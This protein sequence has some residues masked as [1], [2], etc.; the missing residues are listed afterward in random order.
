MAIYDVKG[1]EVSG[2]AGGMDVTGLSFYNDGT[3]TERQG[4]LTYAGHKLYPVNQRT[5][6]KLRPKIY[7]GGLLIALGDSYT[8]MASGNFTSFAA[9]H[10]LVCDNL[11]VGSSTIAGTAGGASEIVGYQPFWNRLDTEIASFPKT[12]G[13]Q[14]YQL[15]DV[16]LVIVMGG[17]NDWYT[18]NPEQ[19]INRLGDPTSTDKAQLWGAIKYIFETL[20]ATFP[21]ADIICIL[22]PSNVKAAESNY[23]MW[24]KEGIIRDAAEMYAIPIC[25]CRFDWY[26]PVNATDRATYW[27][28]DNLHLSSAGKTKLFEKLNDTLNGLAFYR[29]E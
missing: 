26:S 2:S 4:I 27:D 18:V 10:G 16:K 22:Q 15:T 9:E 29:G 23:A 17:A 13:E 5:Q 24:L 28:E 25:D 11:G 8:A 1:D 21:T 20:Y 19:G 12:I 3:S 7:N 14:T 6:R